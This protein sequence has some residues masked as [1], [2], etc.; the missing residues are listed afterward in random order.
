MKAS[1]KSKAK[2]LFH[3]VRGSVKALVGS[4]SSN[5]ALGVK[6]KLERITGKVERRIGKVQ[7][8]CG[9]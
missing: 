7:G 5:T 6:G 1:T 4:M 8:K 9:F 2:G 3:E